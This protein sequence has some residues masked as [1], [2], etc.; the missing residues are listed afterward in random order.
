MTQY[1]IVSPPANTDYNGFWNNG[2][3]N[4][5][6]PNGI[7]L[8]PMFNDPITHDYT[9]IPAS[10]CIDAGHPD[11]QYND[12]DGTRNDM[13]AFPSGSGISE[14]S[15][16]NINLGPEVMSRVV[17]HTPTIYWSSAGEDTGSIQAAY[18][19]EFG[20]DNDWNIAE[21]W[22]TG[23]VFTSDTSVTYNGSTLLDANTYL[24]E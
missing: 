17:N 11:P 13:G 24:L 21:M 4:D 12:P 14:P 5:P 15:P 20:S 23:Q 8:D 10:P 6:G 3:A 19:L 2:S 1:A 9:L 18:E 16:I 7:S 22:T